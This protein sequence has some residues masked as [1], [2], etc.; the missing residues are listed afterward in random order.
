MQK[1]GMPSSAGRE[2]RSNVLMSNMWLSRRPSRPLCRERSGR[3]HSQNLAHD[4]SAWVDHGSAPASGAEVAVSSRDFFFEPTCTTGIQAGT[5]K[6][7]TI[8]A[9]DALIEALDVYTAS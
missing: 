1:P 6:L 2:A 8:F 3:P 7:T 5:V 9:P 4:A